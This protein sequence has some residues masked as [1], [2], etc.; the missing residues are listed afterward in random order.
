MRKVLIV[1]LCFEK[2]SLH[3]NEFVLPVVNVVRGVLKCFDV[4]H[5]LDLDSV[6]LDCYDKVILCGVALKDFEY[7]KHLDKFLWLKDFCGDVLGICA[8]S[9]IVGKVFGGQ[10]SSGKEIGMVD[11]EVLVSDDFLFFEVCLK[12]VYCLHNC[13]CDVPFGFEL[14]AK[15]CDYPLV[16]RK[17]CK[18]SRIYGVLFHPEVRNEKIIQNFINM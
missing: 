6:D 10:I 2:D 13:F 12:E 17:V 14:V 15:S 4:V 9:Q 7:L 11:I 18:S 8:G 5:F 3:F 16:F 1:D